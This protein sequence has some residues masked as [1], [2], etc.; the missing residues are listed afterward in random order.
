[1][2]HTHK[3]IGEICELVNGRAF[4]QSEWSR[5]GLPIVRIQNLNHPK[6]PFNHFDGSYSEKHLIDDGAIL[7]SWSG[8]PGTSFGCFRWD[9][10]PALVNQHIFRVGIDASIV[11]GDYFILALNSKLD[12]MIGHAHGGVGL[13][14][15][16]KR[17]LESILLPIP[18]L[19]EQCRIVARIDECM[20]RAKA[21]ESL[22]DESI[23]LA[24]AALPSTLSEAFD[25]V[26][27]CCEHVTIDEVAIETRY[28]TSQKCTS[29][30]TGMPILRIPNVAGG[31]VNFGELKYCTLDEDQRARIALENGD[32]LFVRTNGS[33]DLVG[34]CAIFEATGTSAQHGF[35]SYLIRVRLDKERVLPPFLAYF[36]NSTHGRSEIDERRRTSAGQFNINSKNLRSIPLPLPPIDVQHQVVDSLK[37]REAN[38]L[39]LQNCLEQTSREEA[40]LPQSILQRAFAGG[41]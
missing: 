24:C 22:R 25:N 36:L 3:S 2:T 10:G 21:I 37:E 9:R 15:I 28:G 20:E 18:S 41:L 7:L 35:A 39:R 13:R 17:K 26:G 31:F 23:D 34:R 4:K 29:T 5:A 27:A 14:H 8:T 38:L 19:R 12:E 16:T 1:M 6:K 33:R 40:L 30:P 32:L 11:D